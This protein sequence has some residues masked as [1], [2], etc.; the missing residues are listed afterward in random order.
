MK[1][2][3]DWQLI[4]HS[5]VDAMRNYKRVNHVLAG[6]LVLWVVPF[7]K[8][9]MVN[10]EVKKELYNCYLPKNHVKN[11]LTTRAK[12]QKYFEERGTT[13]HLPCPIK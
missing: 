5:V 8:I 3:G 2:G 10:Q 11:T 7:V 13:S 4:E 9:N 6:S 1:K 12:R